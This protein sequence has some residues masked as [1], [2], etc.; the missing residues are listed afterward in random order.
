MPRAEGS[1]HDVLIRECTVTTVE[2]RRF[3]I[4]IVDVR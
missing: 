3:H 2:Q 4:T 1:G